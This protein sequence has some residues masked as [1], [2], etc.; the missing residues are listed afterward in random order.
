MRPSCSTPCSSSPRARPREWPTLQQT[1]QRPRRTSSETSCLFSRAS[2]SRRP[3][4]FHSRSWPL[5]RA[6]RRS[7]RI[8]GSRARRSLPRISSRSSSS[9]F[10]LLFLASGAYLD[11]QS[12][13]YFIPWYAGLVCRVGRG[14]P[15]AGA[16]SSGSSRTRYVIAVDRS[17]IVGAIVAVHAWQQVIWYQKLQPDTQS[18]ATLECLKRNGIRGGYAEYWTAYKLTFLAQEEI[19][20][21]PPDGIDRYPHTQSTSCALPAHEQVIAER[22]SWLHRVSR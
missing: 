4:G 3:T 2:R 13:R 1:G 9:S 14:Q 16:R 22:I 17:S 5:S 10:L 12:Y 6:P 8:C 20:I 15:C 11:T 7:Q 19:V 21:A 18:L